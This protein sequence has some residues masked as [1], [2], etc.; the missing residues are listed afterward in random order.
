MSI[1]KFG[2]KKPLSEKVVPGKNFNPED[3]FTSPLYLPQRF[4][5]HMKAKGY[6]CR[7]I[8]Y[9]RLGEMG[10]FNKHGWVPYTMEPED[11]EILG[12]P[13]TISGKDVDGFLRRG[14]VVLGVRSLEASNYYRQSVA[15]RNIQQTLA[16][17]GKPAADELRY[18]LR[19]Q[20]VVLEGYDGDE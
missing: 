11:Y 7:Y 10:G 2:G 9:K 1:G 16:A 3:I 4:K 20:G 13:A 18:A 17:T 8:D 14:S 5:D 12:L 19:G 15:K 6:T